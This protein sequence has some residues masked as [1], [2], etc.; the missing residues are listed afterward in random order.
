L[1]CTEIVPDQVPSAFRVAPHVTTVP[2]ATYA[3]LCGVHLCD[4]L[5]AVDV[6]GAAGLL[7]RAG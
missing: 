5:G 6:L 2:E 3:T 7:G 4:V 1:T